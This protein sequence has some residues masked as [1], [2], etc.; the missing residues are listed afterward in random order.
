MDRIVNLISNRIDL[1][2]KYISIPF[3][4]I[5]YTTCDCAMYASYCVNCKN[6]DSSQYHSSSNITNVCDV[7]RKCLV[8]NRKI[9]AHDGVN[10]GYNYYYYYYADKS[11]VN[12]TMTNIKYMLLNLYT[13]MTC[14]FISPIL[15][16]S[17]FLKGSYE[18]VST[19]YKNMH[20]YD[21]YR[22]NPSAHY[23]YSSRSAH[24]TDSYVEKHHLMCDRSIR[25]YTE[26][27]VL[28]NGVYTLVNKNIFSRSMSFLREMMNIMFYYFSIHLRDR[29][30]RD[31]YL[32]SWVITA[33]IVLFSY[34][35]IFSRNIVIVLITTVCLIDHTVLTDMFE[36]FL[37]IITITPKLMLLSLMYFISML[38]LIIDALCANCIR[39]ICHPF[40]SFDR[41]PSINPF[42]VM[43]GVERNNV[44]IEYLIVHKI[45]MI[46]ILFRLISLPIAMLYHILVDI[47]NLSSAIVI[48]KMFDFNIMHKITR[49]EQITKMIE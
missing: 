5:N 25:Y 33:V 8:C 7:N 42:N 24:F 10:Y 17:L 14:V 20:K 48:G 41:T 39:D 27:D 46:R 47:I 29:N 4:F 1:I 30:V 38:S 18:F 26:G 45:S 6:D 37:I 23:T 16:I 40:L 9:N 15:L 35:N 22:I 36:T 19:I 49:F 13:F 34:S 32:I 2:Y 11:I 28:E 44:M 21:F 31:R 43:P 12:K 3:S